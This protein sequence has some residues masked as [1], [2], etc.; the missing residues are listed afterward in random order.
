MRMLVDRGVERE[1]RPNRL[2]VQPAIAKW[3]NVRQL[4]ERSRQ[5]IAWP[6]PPTGYELPTA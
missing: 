2:K 1:I 3:P 4:R 5:P 6:F